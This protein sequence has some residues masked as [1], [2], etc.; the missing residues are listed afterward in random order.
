MQHLKPYDTL[1]LEVYLTAVMLLQLV[2]W[3]VAATSS[4]LTDVYAKLW[5]MLHMHWHLRCLLSKFIATHIYNMP[6]QQARANITTQLKITIINVLRELASASR[7]A[8]CHWFPA[9][10]VSPAGAQLTNCSLYLPTQAEVDASA[11]ALH[12][13]V[14]DEMQGPIRNMHC[15]FVTTL[16]PQNLSVATVSPSNKAQQA[17]GQRLAQQCCKYTIN[18]NSNCSRP[19]SLRHLSQSVDM[20]LTDPGLPLWTEAPAMTPNNVDCSFLFFC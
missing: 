18:L 11:H 15:V 17:E 16:T 19:L 8:S 9:N 7:H 1:C 20:F 10:K 2:I 12:D 14:L 6:C 13:T 3:L 4:Y 5:A